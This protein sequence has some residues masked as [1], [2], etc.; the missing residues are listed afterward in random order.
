MQLIRVMGRLTAALVLSMAAGLAGC[1]SDVGGGAPVSP[2]LRLHIVTP[3][4]E[5]IRTAFATAFADWYAR[6]HQGQPVVIEWVSLGTPECV[7]YVRQAAADERGELRMRADV[8]FGGGIAD[9]QALA[10]AGLS[11]AL[12]ISTPDIP[13]EVAGLPTRDPGG[14]WFATGLSSFGIVYNAKAI[15]ARGLKPPQTWSDLAKPEFRGWIGLADPTASGSHLQSLV[16]IV[17]KHGWEEGWSTIV[18]LLANCRGLVERSS[19]ALRQTQNGVFLA[20][21]AVNFDGMALQQETGGAVRYVDPPGATALTP[22]VISAI[23]ASRSPDLA[24]AFVQFTLSEEGQALWAVQSDRHPALWHYPV[25]P[26]VYSKYADALSVRIN[27]FETDFG[28]RYDRVAG[29]AQTRALEALVT[30]LCGQNHVAL[31]QAWE[32]IVS[33]G[34]PAEKLKRLTTPPPAAADPLALGKQLAASDEDSATAKVAELAQ[35]F[36]AMLG[37]LKG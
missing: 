11:R 8:M 14:R 31:Q 13:A 1:R 18:R 6:E 27:P 5:N 10:D 25:S 9:H 29:A 32:A 37:A 19:T 7:Q 2:T 4:N 33:A 23:A 35:Q 3:H 30:A 28:V 36:A 21:L 26:T 12:Q 17:Q 16:M 22:D 24:A 20:T 15:E 34:V